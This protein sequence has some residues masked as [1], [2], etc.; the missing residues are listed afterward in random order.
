MKKIIITVKLF[1]LKTTFHLLQE[2][3]GFLCKHRTL[4]YMKL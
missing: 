2:L 4:K 1:S 3:N